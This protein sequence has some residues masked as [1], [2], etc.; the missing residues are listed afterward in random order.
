MAQIP[1]PR[2]FANAFVEL[3]RRLEPRPPPPVEE[4]DDGGEATEGKRKPPEPPAFVPCKCFPEQ[5]NAVYPYTRRWTRTY[6]DEVDPGMAALRDVLEHLMGLDIDYYAL[7]DMA[8][9]VDLVDAMGGIDVYVTEPIESEVSPPREGDPWAYV[10]VEPGWHHF[11]GP[12]ASGLRPSA[13]GIIGLCAHGAAA[14]HGEGTSH[15]R[16]MP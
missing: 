9:F 13:Q 7:I 1:L 2:R 11:D 4:T 3:Q 5:L 12:E 6:P 14:M 16:R 10:K 8:A 15:R